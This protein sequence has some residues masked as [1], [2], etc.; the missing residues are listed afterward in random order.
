MAEQLK[1][2]FWELLKLGLGGYVIG[3]S[4]EKIANSVTKNVD[5]PF[6]RKK[7]RKDVYG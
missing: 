3:R 7:D 6:L 4:A 1:P 5:L 2:E